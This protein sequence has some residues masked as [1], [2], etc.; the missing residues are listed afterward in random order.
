M[1]N[2]FFYVFIIYY[3]PIGLDIKSYI[4]YKYVQKI[5]KHKFRK[6]FKM[7]QKF[8]NAKN[9]LKISM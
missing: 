7:L 5:V 3:L 9:D 1:P 4:Y 2:H 6:D 8:F